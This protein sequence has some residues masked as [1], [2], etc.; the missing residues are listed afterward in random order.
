MGM[1]LSIYLSVCHGTE[2]KACGMNEV[3]VQLQVRLFNK[4]Q[5][6]QQAKN[7]AYSVAVNRNTVL[8]GLPDRGRLRGIPDWS[9]LW[10]GLRGLP[11]WSGSCVGRHRRFRSSVGGLH[12]LPE[13]SG[14]CRLPE[15]SGPWSGLRRLPERNGLWSGLRRLPE[16]NGLWSGLRR[17]PEWNGLWSGLRRLPERGNLERTASAPGMERAMERTP[18]WR[19]S[20]LDSEPCWCILPVTP[21]GANKAYRTWRTL[22]GLPKKKNCEAGLF[23]RWLVSLGHSVAGVILNAEVSL[24]NVKK[25]P[26]WTHVCCSY[27]SRDREESLWNEWGVGPIAGKA[28]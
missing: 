10:S 20:R 21:Q 3:W 25:P 12:R 7:K 16:R 6:C 11:V 8:C 27:L 19:L 17:L 2:R 13:R 9:G 14:L 1:H 28:L 18:S 22:L 24:P 15:R 4:E 23:Q 5:K 26:C